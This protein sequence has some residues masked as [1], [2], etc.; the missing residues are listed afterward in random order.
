[1]KTMWDE[2]Y[3][4]SEYVYGSQPNIF[5]RESID[6]LNPGR[7]LLP[8]EGEGRNAVYAASQGWDVHAFDSSVEGQKKALNLAS[9]NEVVINYQ[10][11]NISDF[12]ASQG[13]DLI[14]LIYVHFDEDWREH[15]FQELIK[16]LNPG[17]RLIME[18]FSKS[19][20][21]KTSGGPKKAEL[22]FSTDELEKHLTSLQPLQCDALSIELDEGAFHQGQAEVIRYIGVNP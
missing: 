22:L 15:F 13:Y 16:S 17:G 11:I 3:A 14:A 9:K 5:F 6:S 19:Q 2:R 18:V 20:L 10:L 8:A 7:L 21:G 12:R 1:M 4:S